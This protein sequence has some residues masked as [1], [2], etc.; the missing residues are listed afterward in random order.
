MHLIDLSTG[1]TKI[2]YDNKLT[3]VYRSETKHIII[4]LVFKNNKIF[5]H[6]N[7]THEMI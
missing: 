7:L 5:K 1:N 4:K 3:S 6:L 2:I